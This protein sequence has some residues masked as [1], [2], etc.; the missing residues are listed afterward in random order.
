M[1][2]PINRRIFFQNSAWAG[3]SVVAGAGLISATDRSKSS[4]DRPTD[5]FS[6][7]LSDSNPKLPSAYALDLDPAQWIWYPSQRTL[8]NTFVLF[9][10]EI[11][12]DS[13]VKSARGWIL[14]DSRYLL[15][16]NGKR[17][18]WGPAPADPRYSEA[19]PLDLIHHVQTGRNVI[20]AT[21][22]YFG[23]GDGTWPTGKPGFIFYLDIEYTNG[24]KQ[25]V[26]SDESWQVKLARSWRPGQYKRWYL[27]ALQEEFDARLYPDGW[28]SSH[29][30]PDTDWI[31]PEILKGSSSKPALN[32]NSADY[33]NN[34]SGDGGST[35]LRKRS[36][37]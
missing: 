24:K 15:K 14:G 27:R 23:L 6:K 30:L 10:K 3:A 12:L 16:I 7:Y 33:L 20:G 25:Q 36:I 9:R 8:A 29:Y 21:V 19:D 31:Q 5:E 28:T 11:I 4:P 37:P 34:S 35:E 13:T 26:L 18:Q 32:T 2:K 22:L 1:D 17:I